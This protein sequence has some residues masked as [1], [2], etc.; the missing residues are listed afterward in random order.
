MCSA[1]H[2]SFSWKK[3]VLILCAEMSP[4]CSMLDGLALEEIRCNEIECF[5]CTSKDD[6]DFEFIKSDM[7]FNACAN[8]LNKRIKSIVMEYDSIKY[9]AVFRFLANFVFII[10]HEIQFYYLIIV[11]L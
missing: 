5:T 9:F 11:L 8:E 10:C 1:I 2:Y 6:E 3:C 7:Q 4:T